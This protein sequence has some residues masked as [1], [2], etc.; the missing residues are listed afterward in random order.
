M[1]A[2]R[3]VGV[4]LRAGDKARLAAGRRHVDRAEVALGER[5]PM[6]WQDG[7]SDRNRYPV[8]NTRMPAG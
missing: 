2:R 3:A 8:A 1:A 4:A 5:G 7:S 6:W